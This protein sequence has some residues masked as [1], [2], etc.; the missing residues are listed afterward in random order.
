[1]N[2]PQGIDVSFETGEVETDAPP[3]DALTGFVAIFR[4]FYSQKEPASFGKVRGVLVKAVRE[5]LGEGDAFDQLKLWQKAHA[6]MRGRSLNVLVARQAW[7][8][9]TE[10]ADDYPPYPEELISLL[11]Y[12]DLIHFGHKRNELS[13]R[14]STPWDDAWLHW[15][16]AD[17]IGPLAH[18]YIGFSGIVRSAMGCSS[19]PYDLGAR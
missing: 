10:I 1:L 11:M 4:Q 2:S 7:P 18:L 9:K 16:L 17:A 14:R 19:A 3:T 13:V 5:T 12:G 15:R 8:N 6:D